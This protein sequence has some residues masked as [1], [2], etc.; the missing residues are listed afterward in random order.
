MHTHA[1]HQHTWIGLVW[2]TPPGMVMGYFCPPTVQA[3][4]FIFYALPVLCGYFFL[5]RKIGQWLSQLSQLPSTQNDAAREITIR[6]KYFFT[7]MLILPLILF[8]A[9]P[10]PSAERL[11]PLQLN[12]IG[13]A[14]VVIWN[15]RNLFALGISTLASG[16][17]GM[18]LHNFAHQ[19][20]KS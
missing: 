16:L 9:A 8:S 2:V 1:Q 20:N 13:S 17:L 4:S 19:Q 7:F 18:A 14:Q 12:D 5:G 15:L 3:Q 11:L 10:P 6:F